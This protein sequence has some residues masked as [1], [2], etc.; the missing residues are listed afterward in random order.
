MINRVLIRIK[1]VQMLYSYLLTR[2]EFKIQPSPGP[3]AT[4]DSRFAYRI[5]LDLIMLIEALSGRKPGKLSVEAE[6]KIKRISA[7]SNGILGSALSL[8]EQVRVATAKVDGDMAVFYSVIDSL[9]DTILDLPEFQTYSRKRE[10]TLQGDVDFWSWA[11]LNVI[12]KDEALLTAARALPDF[13]LAGYERGVEMVVA[14]I[15]SYNDNREMRGKAF[16]ELKRSLDNAYYL[17]NSLLLL[18]VRITDLQERR[19]DAAKH[20][21]MPTQADLYPDTRFIDNAFVACLREKPQLDEYASMEAVE[22]D[23]NDNTVKLLLDAILESETYRNYMSGAATTWVEDCNLWRELFKKVILP[24]DVLLEA[25]EGK[26]IYWNDDLEIMGTF[27]T[28]TIKKFASSEDMGKDVNLLPMYKDKEDEQFGTLLFTDVVNHREE[29]RGLIDR[30]INPEQ[31][32]T[33]RLAFMDIVVMMAAI[34]ELLGFPSIPVAVTLN[35]YIEIANSYST[36]RSGHF[37][38]GVLYSVLNYLKAEGRLL[39]PVSVKK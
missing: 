18:A 19:L 4:R 13:T 23:I 7:L 39:K 38:N 22:W 35:E 31:W 9:L 8:D 34:A 32:D 25:L 1:V 15:H 26:S 37:I 5:Y 12:S 17:Y 33:E 6:G 14:T 30:F 36:P 2:N 20:K 24:S 11:I 3:D 28:K 10:R 16:D 21:Y 27:V 29:Y